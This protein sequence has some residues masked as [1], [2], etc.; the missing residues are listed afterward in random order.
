LPNPITVVPPS[1]A[2]VTNGTSGVAVGVGLRVVVG[3]PVIVG[4][5]VGGEVF[6]GELIG[7][8]VGVL[9]GVL[10]GVSVGVLVGVLV[11]VLVGVFVGVLVGVSVGVLVGVLVFVGVLVGVSVGV[12]V[13]VF[14]DVFVGVFVGVLVGVFV[15]VF[16]GVLV[17][18]F[19]SVFVGV[20]VGVLVGVFVRVLVG[21]FVGVLVGVFVGGASNVTVT[22]WLPPAVLKSQVPVALFAVQLVI[23][24]VCKLHPLNVEPTCAV[25]VNVP[26]SPSFTEMLHG[27]DVQVAF[28]LLSL[29]ST[30]STLPLPVPAKVMSTFLA[31][32]AR[33]GRPTFRTTVQPSTKQETVRRR[34]EASSFPDPACRA[35]CVVCRATS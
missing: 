2:I 7:V 27:F 17:G 12:L 13:G 18:V 3:V 10:V 9:V 23:P 29:V 11:S 8:F 31:A 26:V 16:V 20:L 15:G 30:R 24:A 35:R 34:A 25:A 28:L 33:R 1:F 32:A 6:V 4:V 21:V 22:D 19:V 5:R 14:V